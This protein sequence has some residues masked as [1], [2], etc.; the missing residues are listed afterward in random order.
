MI[1]K[2]NFTN[3][4][5]PHAEYPRPQ[6]KRESYFCLNGKWEYAITTS[7]N[8]PSKYDGDILV[9]FCPESKLSGVERQLKKHEYLHYRRFFRR[10]TSST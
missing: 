9:P 3:E 4:T 7:S 6:F 1:I 10:K 8:T 5:I 2:P